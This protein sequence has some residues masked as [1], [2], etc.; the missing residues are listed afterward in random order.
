M[1]LLSSPVTV[2]IDI[3]VTRRTKIHAV[4][5]GDGVERFH[6]RRISDVLEFLLEHDCKRFVLL[7]EDVEFQVSLSKPLPPVPSAKGPSNG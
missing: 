4:V 7:D 3:P 2:E 6:A 1:S 5:D